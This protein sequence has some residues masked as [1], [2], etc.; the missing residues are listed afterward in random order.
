M[1]PYGYKPAYRFG[2][3]MSGSTEEVIKKNHPHMYEYMR[4]YM[5]KNVS[6]GIN[7]VKNQ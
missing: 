7:K 6:E 1:N 5:S 2:T 4:Q 3:I